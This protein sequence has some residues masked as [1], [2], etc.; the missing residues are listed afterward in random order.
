LRGGG[1]A[2]Q[3]PT[4]T[5]QQQRHQRSGWR[6]VRTLNNNNH[7]VSG[8]SLERTATTRRHALCGWLDVPPQGR[9][10]LRL[11]GNHCHDGGQRGRAKHAGETGFR[12]ACGA[13]CH[14]TPRRQHVAGRGK[15]GYISAPTNLRVGITDAHARRNTAVVQKSRWT[16][17]RVGR[18]SFDCRTGHT[19]LTTNEEGQK[20][21]SLNE[22]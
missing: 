2:A 16:R 20:R 6:C 11:L 1:G 3:R 21:R 10:R 9:A 8:R 18:L 12:T 14:K 13:S 5:G 22:L 7:S 17:G 4:G 19:P 15:N